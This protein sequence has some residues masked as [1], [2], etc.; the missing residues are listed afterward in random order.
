MSLLNN[1]LHSGSN[2]VNVSGMLRNCKNIGIGS[3]SYKDENNTTITVPITKTYYNAAD[4]T[5]KAELDK[6]I[7][8]AITELGK[9]LWNN[10]D[11][12]LTN[13]NTC[14]KTNLAVLKNDSPLWL[15]DHTPKSWG[16]TVEDN[17]LIIPKVS[18][19][20][21]EEKYAE[22]EEKYNEIIARLDKFGTIDESGDL[23]L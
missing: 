5:L 2:S 7:S 14:F 18:Y 20:T 1:K 17:E 10:H 21:L 13:T 4:D 11:L 16:G 9:L 23:L 19:E 22:L 3:Y 6:L 12:N 15:E 8:A